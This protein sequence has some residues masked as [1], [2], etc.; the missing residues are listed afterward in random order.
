MEWLG[1]VD[2]WYS[3]WHSDLRTSPLLPSFCG[4][5]PW[6]VIDNL[7]ILLVY[8]AGWEEDGQVIPKNVY[9]S[10]IDSSVTLPISNREV[11][12]GAWI[13]MDIPFL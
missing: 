13:W 8:L 2:R 10:S 9:V 1:M 7:T 3:V 6:V 4:T 5:P 12:G 11:V